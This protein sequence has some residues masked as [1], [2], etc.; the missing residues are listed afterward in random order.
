MVRGM[1]CLGRL[2]CIHKFNLLHQHD[3]IVSQQAYIRT[4][5]RRGVEVFQQSQGKR[6]FPLRLKSTANLAPSPTLNGVLSITITSHSIS[7]KEGFSATR[8]AN[9]IA[10]ITTTHS[11]RASFSRTNPKSRSSRLSSKRRKIIKNC[12]TLTYS[13]NLP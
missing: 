10:T 7:K 1:W 9:L 3:F 11:T 13:L 8:P 2:I 6:C 5:G 12:P 4:G